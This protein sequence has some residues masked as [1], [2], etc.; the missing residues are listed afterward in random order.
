MT[1]HLL[2][3]TLGLV[4]A[5]LLVLMSATV[6]E[7]IWGTP[8][9]HA[10]I[11]GSAWF[12]A[13]W[14]LLAAASALLM[15]R[16]GLLRRMPTA[17]IH[18]ALLV[19]LA[20]AAVT[21]LTSCHGL[22][23][24]RVGQTVGEFVTDEQLV[25]RFPFALTL[26]H[27]DVEC[28]AGTRS[29]M[30]YVSRLRIEADTDVAEGEVRMNHIYSYA[31]YRFYQSGYDDDRRGCTLA[32]AH[33]PAG[34]ALTYVGYGLL[35][36][37]MAVFFADRRSDFR[38]LLHRWRTAV[39]LALVLIP[40]TASAADRSTDTPRVLPPDVAGAFG[41]LWV[42]HNGRICPLST[43][44]SD[45]TVR[46]CGRPTY[47]GL[48][49]EQVLTG[50]M[51]FYD[52]WQHQ[53]LIR[54]K[55]NAAAAALGVA[56]RHAS[57]SDFYSPDG[58]YRLASARRGAPASVVDADD[59]FNT[60][61]MLT[62]GAMLR[63]FPCADADGGIDW[64][65]PADRIP[66]SVPDAEWI[67]VRRSLDYVA[68]TVVRRDYA[69]VVRL[70]GKIGLYQQRV[71][72][73]VLPS[74]RMRRL[75]QAYSRLAAHSWIFGL[76]IAMGLVAYAFWGIGLA[77][78]RACPRPVRVALTAFAAA[79]LAWLTALLLMRGV[80][81]GRV[82]LSDGFETM[83]FMAWCAL[84]LA[85]ALCRRAPVALPAGLVVGGLALLVSHLGH[86]NPQITP[87]MPVLASP[88]LCIH[89]VVIMIAYSLLAFAMLNGLAACVIRLC[90]RVASAP[91]ARLADLS[92]IIVCPAVF[93]LAAGIF[94]GAVWANVSWGRYWGWD[95]KEVWALVTMMVYS[96]A[97]HTRM[98]PA[99]RRPMAFHVFCVAA[100]L[101]VLVTYFG[102]NML[103]GG[104]HSYA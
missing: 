84:A 85:V 22:G 70:V 46:L 91:V 10:N 26:T 59:K 77:T 101:C 49:P 6:A 93:L 7:K 58:L 24:V 15:V 68:E 60:I 40:G 80:V 100:F 94:V 81:A 27:F 52:D 53:P 11:Y 78:G 67:F 66:P 103:L 61:A 69:E 63:I 16:R 74:D 28:Y 73:G 18:M 38:R 50:W 96:A 3:I 57:L 54:L 9:A 12:A 44:A 19:I 83:Q 36:L 56:G 20:G 17:L 71:A 95:P 99:L 43:L 34:I 39:A 33:D 51:F 72:G 79:L 23:H 102:V 1:R 86:S 88:L 29:P 25:A 62:S 13:L 5:L 42:L 41:N 97:L 21:R 45:L 104:M 98:L 48:T 82:P 37:G 76:C 14:A 30:D 65:S 90:C 92:R 47:R 55:D 75:E 35:L 87:L 31:G 8:F 2:N 32:V 64:L 4:A 89:V